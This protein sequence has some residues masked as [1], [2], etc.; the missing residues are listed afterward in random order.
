MSVINVNNL[1]FS[2]EGSENYIFKDINLNLDT[3]WNLGLIGRNGVGKTTFLKLLL[4]K[5]EYSGTIDASVNFEY[6]PFKI[7]N[8]QLNPY[9]IAK[10]YLNNDYERWKLEK[11]INLLNVDPDILLRP[12]NVLS[13]GEQSKILLAILFLKNNSFLL[14]DEPTNHLDLKG[15]ETVANYLKSKKGFIVISHDRE[16]LDTCIDYVLYINKNSIGIERGNFSQYFK[17]KTEKDNWELNENKKL[18]ND[19]ASLEKNFDRVKKWANKVENSKY[20]IKKGLATDKGYIGHKSA[21]MM[22][23]AITAQKRKEKK[24]EERSNLLKNVDVIEDL[25]IQPL[26]N[27]KGRLLDFYNFSI[28]FDNKKIFKETSFYIDNKDRLQIKG[29]NGC[30]K[31]SILKIIL[32]E[33]LTYFGKKYSFGNLKFSYVPQNICNLSGTLDIYA[34]NNKIDE[35]IFKSILIKLGF[36][37][38]QLNKNIRD[39]SNGQKKKVLIAKSL[40]EKANV[41]VWDEPLNYIDVFSRLQIENLLLKH[42]LTMVFVEHDDAFSK[43]IA[44]KVVNIRKGPE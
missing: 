41:Y 3:N 18:K 30:G 20:N 7:K 17:N 33:N 26:N 27:V 21:K 5:Y 44:T 38:N 8:K 42:K 22:K 16:F 24:I 37:R 15:R 4:G 31:S 1:T 12:F 9:K 34:K 6:F 29:S 28:I 14:I 25:K 39:F 19:I 13:M 35:S 36:N 32:G 2:Y 10:E 23:R 40:C 11:E 43:K